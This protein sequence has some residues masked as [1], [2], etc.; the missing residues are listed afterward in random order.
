[1]VALP[2]DGTYTW[3]LGWAVTPS[4]VGCPP[5]MRGAG[6]D[7]LQ[8]PA[9]IPPPWTTI[10]RA[11][12]AEGKKEGAVGSAPVR[13]ADRWQRKGR[14]PGRPCSCYLPLDGGETA[15]DHK[16]ARIG[17]PPLRQVKT[18]SRTVPEPRVVH[19][20]AV[21]PW[22]SINS[23]TSESAYFRATS[24][25]VRR[26]EVLRPGSAPAF[27]NRDAKGSLPE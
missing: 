7:P 20:S 26:S 4:G 10:G 27:S 2:P 16:D 11:W 13:D 18:N 25:A 3:G 1:M 6:K 5:Y 15:P 14:E 22:R 12:P 24:A 19:W 8:R 17:L 21:L 9:N 23:A